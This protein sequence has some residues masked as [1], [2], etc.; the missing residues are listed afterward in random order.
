M[1]VAVNPPQGGGDG[2][3]QTT[4]GSLPNLKELGP[5]EL[6][7]SI[8]QFGSVTNR[9]TDRQSDRRVKKCTNF[10]TVVP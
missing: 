8:N 5:V 2:E 10:T 1:S 3:A 9:Q 6:G 7:V 4:V